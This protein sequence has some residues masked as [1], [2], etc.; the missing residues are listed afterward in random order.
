MAGVVFDLA[1]DR[2]HFGAEEVVDG[3]GGSGMDTVGTAVCV[4][5]DG[6][7]SADGYAVDEHGAVYGG[8]VAGTD[9]GRVDG[10]AA[11]VDGGVIPGDIGGG[12]WDIRLQIW[13][14][15][16]GGIRRL[17][18]NGTRGESL[19]TTHNAAPRGTALC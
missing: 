6:G 5:F 19:A 3:T 9:M 1:A 10:D 16:M 2:P 11:A 4:Q 8:D 13:R 15:G 7:I 17:D 18:G 12:I 14:W